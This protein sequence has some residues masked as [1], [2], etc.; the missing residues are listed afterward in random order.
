MAGACDQCTYMKRFEDMHGFSHGPAE[1]AYECVNNSE[2]VGT[3]CADKG[4][5]LDFEWNDD[6][7]ACPCFNNCGY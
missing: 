6:E 7:D 2:E 5:A 3:W 1:V 4:E